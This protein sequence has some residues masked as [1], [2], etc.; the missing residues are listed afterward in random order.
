MVSVLGLLH[1]EMAAQESGG[2]IF[3]GSGWES[4]FVY[5]GIFTPGVAASLNG[6]KY[7][8]SY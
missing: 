1:S 3:E 5:A 4:I 6:G 7:R 8:T 2:V